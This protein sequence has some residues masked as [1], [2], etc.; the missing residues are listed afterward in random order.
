[1]INKDEMSPVDSWISVRPGERIEL[2]KQ[3]QEMWLTSAR[4]FRKMRGN[5]LAACFDTEN[6]LDE[7]IGEA[8]FPGLSAPPG[9]R[10]VLTDRAAYSSSYVLKNAFTRI[11]LRTSANTFGR[12]VRLLQD[13]SKEIRELDELLTEQLRADLDR[14]L[15]IRNAFAHFPL[16]FEVR[17]GSSGLA[18]A[19]LLLIAGEIVELT[20]SIC[21]EYKTLV[22]ATTLLVRGVLAQLQSVPKREGES[23]QSKNGIVWLGH[24]GLAE[25]EWR[26]RDPE[27]P[28][29]TADFW[30]RG[31]RPNLKLEVAWGDRESSN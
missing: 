2:N 1:M 22:S 27:H 9:Q 7:I 10:A 4:H 3:M 11:F 12:K 28:L 26:S 25:D 24:T 5:I 15:K 13:I 30:I 31:S 17:A 29:N 16:T 19:A 21:A 6:V 8:F 14:V 20:E 18:L 23:P